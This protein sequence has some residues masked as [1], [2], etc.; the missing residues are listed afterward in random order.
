[1]PV[2]KVFTVV[3]IV[4]IVPTVTI[5]VF[6]QTKCVPQRLS[7]ATTTKTLARAIIP[8]GLVRNISITAPNT[9]LI[10]PALG[11]KYVATK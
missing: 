8:T 5:I 10:P 11:D 1:M 6:L 4:T 3:T 2:V 9:L 7:S